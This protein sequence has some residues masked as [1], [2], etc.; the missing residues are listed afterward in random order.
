MELLALGNSSFCKALENGCKFDQVGEI[1]EKT[2]LYS[3]TK[4][5]LRNAASSYREG[6]FTCEADWAL[7]TSTYF[8]GTWHLIKADEILELEGRREP[9]G[10]ASECLKSAA[11]L[12]GRAGYETRKEEVIGRLD[13]VKEESKIIISAMNT[14]VKP[15]ITGSAVGL[16]APSLPEETSSPANISE[17][18]KYS[19]QTVERLADKK[20][21]VI[22]EP[23]SEKIEIEEKKGIKA[24]VMRHLQ[25]IIMLVIMTC[26][27]ISLVLGLTGVL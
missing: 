5:Y 4:M 19:L 3:K 8:D 2:K 17:M 25:I 18:W 6:G 15:S 14:I 22:K 13:M 27:V 26:A 12:F 20:I 21:D 23:T 24:W 7:A 11:E 9:L 10:I 1:K 16:I